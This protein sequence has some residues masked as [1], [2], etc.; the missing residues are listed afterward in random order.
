M[1][2]IKER[3][4]KLMDFSF[5]GEISLIDYDGVYVKY[6]G[7]KAVI[8]SKDKTTLARAYFLL[9]KEIKKGNTDFEISQKPHFDVCGPMLALSG[10]CV[11]TV[12]AVKNYIDNIAALGLNMLMLYT[13]MNYELKDYPLFGYLRGRYTWDELKEID[14]YALEMGVEV[15]PCIQTLGHLERFLKWDATSD[16]RDNKS[17][18]LIGEEKTYKFIEAEINAMRECFSSKRIHIGMDEA[19]GFGL[20]NYFIK[21]GY[22]D[23]FDTFNEHLAKVCDIA[24]KYDFKPM[25]WCDM[26]YSTVD[27]AD[28]VKMDAVIPEKAFSTVPEDLGLVFWDYYETKYEYYNKKLS[29]LVPFNREIIFGGGVWSWDGFLPNIRFT[30]DT[31]KPALNVCLDRDIKFVIATMWGASGTEANYNLCIGGLALFSEYCYLGKD[32]TDDDVFDVSAA[33]T[34]DTKEFTDAVSDL[35]LGYDGAVSAGK[36]AF[37][38][39]ILLPTVYYDFDYKVMKDTYKESIDT[40]DKY[41]DHKYYNFYR[42]FFEICYEKAEVFLNLRDKYKSGDKEYLKNIADVTIPKLT[43]LYR[44]FYDIFKNISFASYKKNGF[45]IVHI[46]I[47]GILMRLE[48]AAGVLNDY[49][50][51]NTDIIEE[52]ENEIVSGINKTWCSPEHYLSTSFLG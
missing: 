15:I 5:N 2:M 39:D 37:Y 44:K 14:S 12:D 36:G 21:H 23:R 13:E 7:T 11:M 48:Y 52:L 41:K 24:K 45:E 51:G 6:D 22:R 33:L 25:I 49:V 50:D 19:N 35:A 9:A 32:C 47:G 43:K 4:F 28:Y 26:Y 29:D 3:I 30:F 10:G 46:R 38:G 31:M 27:P 8:G 16:I 20:G 17:V 40:L 1:L 34:G 18:L 42:T